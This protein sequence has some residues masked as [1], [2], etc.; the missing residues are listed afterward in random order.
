MTDT[1]IDPFY[2]KIEAIQGWLDPTAGQRTIDIL[3]WQC[4]AGIKGDLFEIGVFCGKYFAILLDS[5]LRNGDKVLGVDTFEFAPPERVKTEL[6]TVFGKDVSDHIQLWQRPSSTLQDRHLRNTIGLPRFISIDGA[7]DYENVFRDLVL[8]DR[9]IAPRGLIAV[10]DFL[11]PMTLGVN[12]AVG[13]FFAQPRNVVPVAYISNK[14]FLAH[15]SSH[16]AYRK[17]FEHIIVNA[18]DKRSEIFRA[19]LK[20]GRNHIEQ[21]FFGHMVLLS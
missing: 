9:I 7:H 15:C 12:Q 17:A 5:A 18:D 14:L 2:Q 6:Q 8:C 4:S 13:A 21:P 10:D 19:R 16:D 11:N 3:N 20:N 1:P